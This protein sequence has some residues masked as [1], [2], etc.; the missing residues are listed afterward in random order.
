MRFLT[1]G[2]PMAA[3]DRHTLSVLDAWTFP[4]RLDAVPDAR[5]HIRDLARKVYGYGD[6]ADVVELAAGELL[7]NGAQHGRGDELAVRVTKT[8]TALRVEVHDDGCDGPI[9]DPDKD[10]MGESGRGLFLARA[11]TTKCGIDR[12][13]EGTTAWFEMRLP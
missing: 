1:K 11:L 10:P 8:R 5:H 6:P 3:A 4:R 9:G 12:N 13:A 2:D 7:A